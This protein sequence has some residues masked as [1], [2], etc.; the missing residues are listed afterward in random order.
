MSSVMQKV[1]SWS[2][3][4]GFL[5]ALVLGAI[6]LTTPTVVYALLVLGL[7][8]GILNISDKEIVPFLVATVALIVAGSAAGSISQIPPSISN[9]LVNITIFVVPAAVI[10]SVKAIY[11]LASSR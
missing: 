7:V 2:F 3:I 8:V 10:G 6:G 11:A 4:V 9:I 5:I 1:G